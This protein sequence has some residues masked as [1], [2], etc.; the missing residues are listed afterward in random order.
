MVLFKK[1]KKSLFK[2]IVILNSTIFTLV[3]LFCILFIMVIM[4]YQ[5]D[6]NKTNNIIRN[7]NNFSEKCSKVDFE[8]SGSVFSDYVMANKDNIYCLILFNANGVLTTVPVDSVINN[9]TIVYLSQNYTDV[10]YSQA[11]NNIKR[12]VSG[13]CYDNNGKQIWI[14]KINKIEKTSIGILQFKDGSKYRAM[15]DWNSDPIDNSII[16]LNKIIPFALT[17]I[18]LVNIIFSFCYS[19]TISKPIKEISIVSNKMSDDL[20]LKSR[21]NVNRNDEIGQLSSNINKLGKNLSKSLEEVKNKN[22]LLK[23]D[24]Q[25]R[26]ELKKKRADFFNA[27]SHEL[28]TP[29]TILRGQLEGMKYN[30]G[31]YKDR[32]SFSEK[33]LKVAENMT[34]LVEEISL[35]AQNGDKNFEMNIERFNL[36]E[37]VIECTDELREIAERRGTQIVSNVSS[38]IYIEADYNNMKKVI[39]NVIK[40]GIIHSPIES[41]IYVDLCEENNEFIFSTENTNAHIPSDELEYVFNAY[42]RVEKSRSKRNG[43]TGLGLYIVKMILM[44]HNLEFNISNK[45]NSVLF[46]IHFNKIRSNHEEI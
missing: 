45:D 7:F 24:V 18:I 6:K 3:S 36:S 9:C 44:Q 15:I 30:I 23:D 17:V 22:V 28:K 5:Y 34:K 32:K 12:Q 42:Y 25:K 19:R 46:V 4:P 13:K 21:S 20:D 1:V 43:G 39:C 33:S 8:N 16:I 35:I 38:K 29:I 26:L 2:E 31:I 14:S 41:S 11:V 40:N 27:A 37:L 10:T